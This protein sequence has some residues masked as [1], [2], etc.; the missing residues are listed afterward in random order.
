MLLVR[1]SGLSSWIWVSISHEIARGMHGI[2]TLNV[3]VG[4]LPVGY[5]CCWFQKLI[6]GGEFGATKPL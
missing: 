4:L 3:P 5:R 1:G 6:M 2:Y